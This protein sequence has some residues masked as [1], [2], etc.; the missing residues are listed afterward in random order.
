MFSP[1]MKRRRHERDGAATILPLHGYKI[2]ASCGAALF[3]LAR[4][5]GEEGDP[6]ALAR[7]GGEGPVVP[8]EHQ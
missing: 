2:H 7:G 5:T 4:E 3:V 8:L 6:R 1:A